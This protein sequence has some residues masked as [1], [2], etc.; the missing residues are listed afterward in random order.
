[1]PALLRF[2][3]FKLTHRLMPRAMVL[4]VV[5]GPLAAYLLLGV[6]PEEGDSNVHDL[7]IGNVPTDGMFIV[8]QLGM[9]LAVTLAA[10]SVA[11][12]YSWG[13]LRT[14]LPRTAGRS[15]FL[16]AKLASLGLF[17][18]VIVLCGLA[19]ALVGSTL[20]TELRDL[21]GSVG[22]GFAGQVLESL[23]RTVWS[24][25]PYGAL[26]FVVALWS[27]SSAAGIAI[28]IVVFYAEV[29]LTPLFTSTGA[30]DWLPYALIYNNVTAVLGTHALLPEG[31]IPGAW[32]AA[33][34][35]A[36]HLTAFITL[37]YGRFLTRDVT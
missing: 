33:G 24:V 22:S 20:V 32:Q 1:M 19:A 10:S 17:A 4:V 3:L 9:I 37:A 27:R 23:V 2:E 26:A 13:T 5:G 11:T 7:R 31:D 18:V 25:L 29:L 21:D 8:Y 6:L 34:V 30:L 14:V 16:T 35:L 28:P 12:E 15:A 36:A